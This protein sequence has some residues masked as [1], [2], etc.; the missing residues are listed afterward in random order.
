MSQEILILYIQLILLILSHSQNLIPISIGQTIQGEFPLDE[1]HRYY[2]LTIPKNASNQLLIITT[3][4]DSST[5]SN[6]KESFS[7][8]DFYIS[9]KNKYPSSKR[10]SEWFSE[11]YGADIMSI[12]SESVKENDIFYIGMYCQFKCK[13]FLKIETG[14]ESE[15]QFKQ[16]YNVKLKSH[17]SM[18][19]KIKITQDFEKLKVFA[20]SFSNSKFKIFMNKNSPSSA[21]TFKVIP[22]WDSGYTIIVKQGTEQYCTNCEYHIIVHN[23]ETDTNNIND[24][25][26]QATTEE[27]YSSNN[28]NDLFPIFDALEMDSKTCFNFN[29]TERQKRYEKLILDLV[30]YSGDATLLIEGWRHKDIN[31]KYDA[32]KSNY[33]HRVI[34]EKHIILDKK[35]FEVFD[36]E[37][38]Y[39]S[40]R[41][42]TLHFCLFSSRQISYK[43]QAYF[44]SD[45]N[46]IKHS[47]LLA[48]GYKLRTYLL[49]DQII[50]Y[51]LLVDH[52]SKS[53]YN[54]ETNLTVIQNVVV[55][56]TSFNGYFCKEETC[57]L[58]QLSDYEKIER[59]GEFLKQEI[60]KPDPN[61]NILY[62]NNNNNYC[63]KYP[64]IKTKDGNEIDC[65]ALAVIKCDTPSEEN[66]MCIF[67]IQLHIKDTEL[68]MKS[69]EVYN[70]MLP[71]GKVD[72]YKIIIS[73][74]NIKDLFIVLNTE[75]GNAQL[76]VYMDSN[77]L[78]NKQ[79]FISVSTHNDYIPDVVRVTPKKI[80]KENL[81]GTYT[82]KVYPETFSTY[83]IY[84]YTIYKQD[85]DENK[86][87]NIPEVTMNLN[88]GQ[89]ILD[90]FPNDIRYKIYSFSPLFNKKSTIK[91]FINRVNIDFNIYV[92]SDISKFEIV[93][94]YDLRKKPNIEQIKGYQWKSNTNN[95][96]IINK[97][98]EN[99]SLNKIL[100]I[101]VAPTNPL[102][103]TRD[104]DSKTSGDKL[105]SKFYI[106]IIS[107]D[108]P[109]SVTE[110]MP[111][112]MT[113][114]NSYSQQMYLRIHPDPKKN[115]ELVINL[116]LGEI[117]IFASTNYFTSDDINNLDIKSAK[118]NTQYGA[119]E[120]D[121]FIFLLNINSFTTFRLTSDYINDNS[122]KDT[123]FTNINIYYYIRRS[124]SMLT[125]N[126]V[127]QYVLLE[128]TSET[129]AQYL[130]PSFF[131]SGNLQ[132][133]HKTH[134]IIEEVEKRKSAFITVNFKQ[135]FGNV[136]VRIPETP[137]NSNNMRFPSEGYYDYKGTNIYSGKL[138]SIPE[139]EFDK[140]KNGKLQIIITITA[141]VGSYQY[142]EENKEENTNQIKYSISYSNAPKRLNQNVPY[143]GFISQG[144][145]QYFNL[146]FDKSTENIYI[147]LTNMNG[148]ADMFVKKGNVLP[149]QSN[150][151]WCS[152]QNNHE[153]IEISKD[154]DFFKKTNTSISGYYGL[155][156]VGFIDT[157]FSLFV[158]SHKNKV[159][160]LRD[161]IPMGCWCQNKGD[162]CFFRYN[163]V[164]DKESIENGLDHND[165]VFTS[166]Y[167]YGA[168]FMYAKVVLDNEL[169]DPNKAEFYSNFP[170]RNN[171][172][173]S[174]KESNQLNFIKL[175]VGGEKYQRDAS[176]LLTF[177]CN[178][179]T[180]VDITP[181][182]L[183][184]FSSVDYI[185]ENRENIYYLGKNHKTKEQAQL[186]LIINNYSEKDKDLIYSVH[187]YVGDAHFK[188]YGNS[189]FWDSKTQK[190]NYK[191][192]LLN[193]FD[194]I[195]KDKDQD[196][197]IEVYN[198]YSRDYHNYI[199]KNDK[200][201]Y[202]EIY[203]YVEPKGDFGFFLSYNFDKNWNLVMI[204]KS[205]SF[206]VINQEFYGYFDINEEYTDVEF[207][208]WV[209]NNLKMFAEVYI[210]INIVD[211][212]NINELRKNPKKKHD[213]FSI[214][215]YSYP[216]TDNWDYKSTTDQTLG[217][218]SLNMD[219]FPKLREEDIQ[220]GLKFVRALFYVRLGETHFEPISEENTQE[221][222]NEEKEEEQ[223]TDESKT[224]INIVVTPGVDY[225]KYVELK[226]F[227]Y[228][229]STLIY[230]IRKRKIENKVY[231]LNVENLNHDTLVIEI[232]TCRG[233]YDINIQE[234]LITKDNLKK[235]SIPYEQFNDKGKRIIYIEN[236]K[237][238]HYYLNV[239][240]KDRK[241]YTKKNRNETNANNLEYL[242]YYYTTY[243]ENL[244][245]QDV[246]KWITHSP[247]GKGQI[248]LD[249]P[250]II[251]NDLDLEEKAISDY[252][253]D[254]FATKD[255]DYTSSMGSI[256]YLSRLTP[257]E[258][259]VF[260]IESMSVQ[261]K[262]SLILKNLIPGNRYYINV[263]AQNLKTKELIAFHPIEVFTG[264]LHPHYRHFF[265]TIFI[266]ALIFGFIYFAYKYKTTKDELIFLKGDALPRSENEI[267]NMGYE[268][269]NVKYTGLGSGY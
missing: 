68:I 78:Y 64:K 102:N 52:V 101:I 261:N 65:V 11:Q 89:L 152:N 178:Q 55:G 162:K 228:Y 29:I 217:K 264:G 16:Y 214:Y 82:I 146:Y 6:T 255:E 18:N 253:F 25:F 103:F 116:L 195:T 185:S 61:T 3:H 263:L 204:G 208:L 236:I 190:L 15:M 184:H 28:M 32:D 30:V 268:A 222:R 248:K 176:I 137:Q 10:S 90:F 105:I 56:K 150:S 133:G 232:S 240:P 76:S 212:S 219:H 67:D 154:D 237:S 249:L 40:N 35:D 93:Q 112:T 23:G 223:S 17:E 216:S 115:L 27:K 186:T 45:F 250:L 86:N 47:S 164:Y 136:F 221:N 95:E 151:D 63:L 42:S 144:E 74:E 98:D 143:D 111:H 135:G 161:N 41:D 235:R 159:F 173:I 77:N 207:N 168:G 187:S 177:E 130:M 100:Y 220:T 33:S 211:K 194:I 254:V 179:K 267:R 241:Y 141:E 225:F 38:S 80:R 125:Q 132:I 262:T 239:R 81:V 224:L 8:P 166:Q 203:I 183:K 109:F 14:K 181:T 140:L 53:E 50:T 169:H 2:S 197:N 36:K 167:L 113:L 4:E 88:E 114:S 196:F 26:I 131:F 34:M 99:F 87:K 58:T 128:R 200:E 126:K 91:I 247:Y 85:S 83:K 193:E 243:S 21:N 229:Y 148:D 51:E 108:L 230:G 127:V 180:K 198:P 44:L 145:V 46:K 139:K 69:K 106:G 227:E 57:N 37:D 9:K 188:L 218:I 257:N 48:P 226:P 242:I 97:N 124:E 157:S 60:S 118:Y 233:L 258:E 163:D 244:E 251:T 66:D 238:K 70:G 213:K 20:Y 43:F 171:Y 174:N 147:G 156:L 165:F 259:R 59:N 202:E 117:D 189:S 13:Y 215:Q 12:P 142:S 170:D 75:S 121:K 206:Y 265:R 134:F 234:E 129:K 158:S 120:L 72:L 155:L 84:Y 153:Y 122:D 107:E 96:V 110:G 22:C 79:T 62:I 123:Q 73:D 5:S 256:C 269:P 94:L 119:Y 7:D 209:Q 210:K 71:L 192:K 49:K 246:D 175:K 54:I 191:Y 24:I 260:K 149:T 252:K 172:D 92:F 201:N 31:N 199:D 39:Y 19:Y 104:E 205:Q 266:L 160:P 182:S 138:I 231:A 1:S 245:F